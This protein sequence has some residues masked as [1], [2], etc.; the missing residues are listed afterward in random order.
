[1]QINP[2]DVNQDN[3]GVY[4]LGLTLDL[5]DGTSNTTNAQIT[6]LCPTENE[7]ALFEFE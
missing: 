4:E 7:L 3:V 1:M 2:S 5:S 6:L